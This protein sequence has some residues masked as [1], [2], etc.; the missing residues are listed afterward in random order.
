MGHKVNPYSFR[1]PLLRT[2]TSRW[3]SKKDYQKLLESDI[4]IREHLK[5][6]LKRSSISDIIVERSAGSVGIQIHTSKPGMVIGRGGGGIEQLSKDIKQHFFANEKINVSISIQEVTKPMLNAELVAQNMVEQI[7][8]RIPFRR[9][10]KTTIDQ[11]MRA[12]ALGVKVVVSGRLNG[13]D[14]ARTE[15][16][17]EGKVP[18]HTIRADVDYAGA[19]AATTYGSIGVK[20]WIYK[21][22]IFAKEKK[23]E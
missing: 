20:V 14:I 2:W 23:K 12:G 8:K 4:R 1:I 21:G 19:T 6:K 11:V 17:H 16:L 13:A 7:E 10:L 5:N 9:V 18:L 3:F 15:K 22:E